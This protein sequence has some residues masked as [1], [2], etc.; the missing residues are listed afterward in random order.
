MEEQSLAGTLKETARG[1]DLQ[2]KR[3]FSEKEVNRLRYAQE[4]LRFLMDRNY[5]VSPVI[6]LIGDRYQLSARQR[7]ALQRSTCKTESCKLRRAKSLPLNRLKEGPIHIDGFNLIIT[8]EVALS[9]GVILLGQDGT[10]RD[11]AGLRGTYRIIDKTDKALELLGNVFKELEAKDITFYLDAPVSNSGKL[12]VKL[13][14]CGNQW[15]LP[16][17]VNLVNN[18]DPLLS[19]R[20]RVVT[21][22]SVILDH[23]KSYFNLAVYCVEHYIENAVIVNLGLDE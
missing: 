1:V 12:K 9:G 10:I 2:D 20:E 16:L 18:P 21:T 11:L 3:F 5:P 6:K 23:C 14:E 22:D 4:E 7:L 17:Q 15:R 8:L 13:L 19:Q